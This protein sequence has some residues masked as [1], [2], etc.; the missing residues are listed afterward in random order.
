MQIG[1]SEYYHE[2]AVDRDRLRRVCDRLL[3]LFNYAPS[4]LEFIYA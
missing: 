2:K 1:Q 3:R 4:D